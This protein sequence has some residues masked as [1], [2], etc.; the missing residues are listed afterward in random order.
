MSTHT[1]TAQKKVLKVVLCGNPNS[2]EISL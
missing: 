1:A 2:G